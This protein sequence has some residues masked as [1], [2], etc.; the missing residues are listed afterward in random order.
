[1][2]GLG[3]VGCAP[4]MITLANIAKQ[5]RKDQQGNKKR[6]TSGRQG[7]FRNADARG[8]AILELRVQSAEECTKSDRVHRHCEAG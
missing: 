6:D 3:C 7:T 4:G 2:V 5:R 8:A 1:M